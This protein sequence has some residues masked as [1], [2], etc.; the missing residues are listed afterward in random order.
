M[1]LRPVGEEHPES[2]GGGKT[3]GSALP[4]QARLLHAPRPPELLHVSAEVAV[5]ALSSHTGPAAAAAGSASARSGPRPPAARR[6]WGRQQR[7]GLWVNG[8]RVRWAQWGPDLGNSW[9]LPP[10]LSSQ[11][12]PSYLGRQGTRSPLLQGVGVTTL[13]TQGLSLPSSSPGWLLWEPENWLPDFTPLTL[14][15][16]LLD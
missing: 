8:D 10:F 5:P 16:N 6:H 13:S 1:V 14:P 9:Q 7:R 3:H 11:N 15:Q 12:S 2:Q 4:E